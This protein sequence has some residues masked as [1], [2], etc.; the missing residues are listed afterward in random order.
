MSAMDDSISHVNTRLLDASTFVRPNSNVPLRN[1]NDTFRHF[2][3]NTGGA[4]VRGRDDHHFD[5]PRVFGK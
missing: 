2:N 5:N 1:R 4:L 3:S